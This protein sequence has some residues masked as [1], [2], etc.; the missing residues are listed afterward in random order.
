M[1]RI[2]GSSD[3]RKAP[4]ATELEWLDEELR[5]VEARLRRI[6]ATSRR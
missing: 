1:A 2:P 4:Y 5:W 6:V 3:S